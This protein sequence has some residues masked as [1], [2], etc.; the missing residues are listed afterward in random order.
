[1]HSFLV[2]QDLRGLLQDGPDPVVQLVRIG[3]GSQFVDEKRLVERFE[4]EAFVETVA[5]LLA[6]AFGG[7]KQALTGS[8][9]PPVFV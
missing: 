3:G 4:F 1:M 9:T 2:F 7:G 8:A 6:I 5:R